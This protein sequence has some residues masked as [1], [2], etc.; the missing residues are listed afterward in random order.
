M[1]ALPRALRVPFP[2]PEPLGISKDPSDEIVNWLF[3]SPWPLTPLGSPNPPVCTR[4]DGRDFDNVGVSL[5][6]ANAPTCTWGASLG[7]ETDTS[8][9]TGAAGLMSTLGGSTTAGRITTAGFGM[10][11]FATAA[12]SYALIAGCRLAGNV[13]VVT[14]GVRI[15][16]FATTTTLFAFMTPIWTRPVI[17]RASNANAM[18]KVW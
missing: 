2:Y 14:R 16:L 13:S 5:V 7:R 1:P 17:R 15:S 10:T 4:S 3:P 18:N 9:K 11:S 6:G 8:V 12:G